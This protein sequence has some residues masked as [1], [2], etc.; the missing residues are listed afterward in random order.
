MADSTQEAISVIQSPVKF[1]NESF[2]N[3]ID[4]P[5]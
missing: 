1:L 2:W 3:D 4:G 5:G